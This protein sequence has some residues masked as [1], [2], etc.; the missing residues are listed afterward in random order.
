MSRTE[1]LDVRQDRRQHV[2]AFEGVRDAAKA[3]AQQYQRSHT[4]RS[5]P[6]RLQ[7]DLRAERMSHEDHFGIT[8]MVTDGIHV[9]AV[10][11]DVHLLAIDRQPTAP[12]TTVM[13]MSDR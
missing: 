4:L 9:G 5:R 1:I 13:E 12:M 6:I 7:A 2:G 3:P 8:E 10:S 11:D